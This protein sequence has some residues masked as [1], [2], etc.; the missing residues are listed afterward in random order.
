M[1]PDVPCFASLI[2]DQVPT[3]S[4]AEQVADET[5]SP[6]EVCPVFDPLQGSLLGPHGPKLVRICVVFTVPDFCSAQS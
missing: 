4:V 3:T 6:L 2:F 5:L 1:V